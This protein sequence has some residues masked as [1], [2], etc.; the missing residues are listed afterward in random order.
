MDA[1]VFISIALFYVWKVI[2]TDEQ[3][4]RQQTEESADVQ[5]VVTDNSTRVAKLND[6]YYKDENA[7]SAMINALGFPKR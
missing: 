6:T 1:V 2:S 4:I 3:D 5:E 7:F